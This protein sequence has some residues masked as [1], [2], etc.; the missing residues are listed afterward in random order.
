MTEDDCRNSPHGRLAYLR[1]RITGFDPKHPCPVCVETVDSHGREDG[2]S[3]THWVR[4]DHLIAFDE[5][6]SAML[7]RLARTARAS[8]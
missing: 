8:V 4:P 1:V 6:K 3:L 7:A 5:A 2:A